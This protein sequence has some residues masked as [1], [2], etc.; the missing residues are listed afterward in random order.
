[1]KSI[2]TAVLSLLLLL[3]GILSAS[4]ITTES[5]DFGGQIAVLQQWYRKSQAAK[6]SIVLN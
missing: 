3:A 5:L 4:Y 1:M 6:V 2:Q